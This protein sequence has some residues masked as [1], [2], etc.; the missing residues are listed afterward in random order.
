MQ[1]R[2]DLG[3]KHDTAAVS[4]RMGGHPRRSGAEIGS[5]AQHR[6]AIE[7]TVSSHITRLVLRTAGRL[8]IA[9][10]DAENLT[11][12]TRHQLDDD[13]VRPPT[14]S[15]LRLWEMMTTVAP[16]GMPGL[17]AAEQAAV[18]SLHVWDYLFTSGATLADG[19]Q[20][21]AEYLHLLVDPSATMSVRSD[22]AQLTLRYGSETSW[23][24][25][26]GAIHEF[27][28]LLIL[29]RC[30]EAIGHPIVPLHV[31]F[32]HPAPRTSQLLAD[33][34]GTRRLDFGGQTNSITFLGSDTQPLQ[35]ADPELARIF[36]R[37]AEM[38]ASSS[39]PLPDWRDSFDDALAKAFAEKTPS[40]DAVAHRLSLSPRT[41]QRRLADY[42]TTWQQQLDE[43]R[44]ARAEHLL[45]HAR[46]S[47]S[48]VASHLGYADARSLRRALQRWGDT[49]KLV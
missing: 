23:T 15:L 47:L 36:R 32:A 29:R 33:A 17:R 34:F 10:A 40:L 6:A 42:G 22:G 16:E 25:A 26:A 43:A 1:E 18:G 20:Q 7:G 14:N 11:G 9:T 45:H 19:A 5:G 37:Y 48:T 35:P 24:T 30:R 21:A 49:E 8:G 31:G 46:M 44:H 3:T 27:I 13:L 41:V 4:S 28:M 39:R 38:T 12:L 2:V